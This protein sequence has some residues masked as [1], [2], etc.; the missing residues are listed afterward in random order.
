M[1]EL[2]RMAFC[3]YLDTFALGQT[4]PWLLLS[5]NENVRLA[6]SERVVYGVLDVDNVETSIVAFPMRDHTN[7]AHVTTTSD[8]SDNT[9]IESNE[10][11]DFAGRQIDL[12]GIVDL[13]RWVGVSNPTPASI[14][15]AFC[16]WLSTKTWSNV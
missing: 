14:I 16:S 2:C 4:D 5:D 10:V 1:Y 9:S 7:T 13:D 6:G 11:G 8:H 12:H 15:S 3:A